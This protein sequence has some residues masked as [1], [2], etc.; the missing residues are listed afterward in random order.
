MFMCFICFVR[1]M[2]LMSFFVAGYLGSINLILSSWCLNLFYRRNY[3]FPKY[4]LKHCQYLRANGKERKWDEEVQRER[5]GVNRSRIG[6]SN[7][8]AF[9]CHIKKFK[10]FSI[11]LDYF[12]HSHSPLTN[13]IECVREQ[14][15][16]NKNNM[17]NMRFLYLFCFFSFKK[18]VQ[19]KR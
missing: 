12:S 10:R 8:N 17:K 3:G 9:A 16:L 15:R 7:P 5:N 4:K 6:G 14:K 13:S 11:R 1:T 2:V 19:I 18:K